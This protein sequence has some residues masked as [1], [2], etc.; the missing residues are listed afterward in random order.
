MWV[1]G[2]GVAGGQIAGEDPGER[3]NIPADNVAG[4]LRSEQG[5]LDLGILGVIF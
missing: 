1:L 3:G 4:K 5:P 2:S